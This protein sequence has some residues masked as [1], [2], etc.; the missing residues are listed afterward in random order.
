M[1][2]LTIK[3]F[4]PVVNTLFIFLKAKLKF[5]NHTSVWVFVIIMNHDDVIILTIFFPF[6]SLLI[7][8]IIYHMVRFL[9]HAL[10]DYGMNFELAASMS[11]SGMQWSFSNKVSAVPQL[12]SFK[13]A[14]DEKQ[15]KIDPHVSTETPNLTHRPYSSVIQ[16][17]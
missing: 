8:K 17:Q 12:L 7:C 16:V 1:S 10:N 2:I 4:K 9:N 3:Y 11:G 6:F 15:R 13:A 14:Q 5:F